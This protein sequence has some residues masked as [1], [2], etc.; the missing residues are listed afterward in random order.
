LEKRYSEK[1]LPTEIN[2]FTVVQAIKSFT[3]FILIIINM[4]DSNLQEFGFGGLNGLMGGVFFLMS[5]L[6]FGLQNQITNFLTTLSTST[7]NIGP[8]SASYALMA[9]IAIVLVSGGVNTFISG[10]N[11]DANS[12]AGT[13]VLVIIGLMAFPS[14]NQ[15][16]SSGT[17]GTIL[18]FVSVA[19]YSVI[20]GVGAES[21]DRD[22]ILPGIRETIGGGL[23]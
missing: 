21:D 15:W 10:A 4:V 3:S 1:S 22:S 19:G 9:S 12:W 14:F 5:A 2:A 16:A 17:A 8:F 6:M 18:F 23:R 20:G 13:L 11:S 7:F